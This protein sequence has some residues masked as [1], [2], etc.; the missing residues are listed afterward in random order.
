MR[1][2]LRRGGVPLLIL[3]VL[4]VWAGLG[5]R[6]GEGRLVDAQGRRVFVADGDTL[7]IGE[8]TIRLAGL[9]AVERAQF[10]FDAQ[11]VSWSCGQ[12]A[13]A[14]LS[15]IV[16]KGD[17]RCTTI[18]RDHY[19]RTVARCTVAENVDVGAE[20]VTAGLAVADG[21]HYA[22]Q[23]AKALTGKRGIWA[24][25]FEVPRLWRDRHHVEPKQVRAVH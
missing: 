21:G 4:L 8:E 18:E 2:L 16:A 7:R 6:E 13:S 10:C 5:R 23:Q 9:D 1:G 22:A 17:L 3:L 19:G 20:L 24:G 25:R 15:E 14:A 11:G 12:T